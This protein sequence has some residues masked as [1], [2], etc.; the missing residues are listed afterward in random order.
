MEALS[1]AGHRMKS[2]INLLFHDV[3]QHTTNESGFSGAGADRYKL[4]IA[5]FRAQLSSVRAVRGDKPVLINSL[6]EYGSGLLPFAISVDDGGISYHSIIAPLLA[7]HG[8]LGHCLITTG[9]IG[10]PGFLHKQHIRELHAA[11]HLIGSHSVNHP[12]VFSNLSW[13]QL[14]MEWE[15]SKQTLEDI[16]GERIT[17][18]SVPGGS[19]SRNVAMA[20]RA[21][22]LE[23]LMTSEPQ[24]S[25]QDVDGC[26]VSGRFTLRRNSPPDLAG[27]LVRLKRGRRNQQWLA[28]NSKKLLKR[29]LGAGYTRA[30]NWLSR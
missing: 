20:A 14:I 3:Y 30:C 28:W 5:G 8:W 13:D 21:A 7:E 4:P 15:Q 16:I 9:H 25:E 18:G 11:G 29:A 12:A 17:V 6:P 10:Q 26:H 24:T 22:G 23:I 27:K 2:L 1:G 19:Y